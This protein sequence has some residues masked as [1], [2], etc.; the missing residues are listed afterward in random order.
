MT[1]E[2]TVNFKVDGQQVI[3]TLR[4]PEK[5]GKPPV[6]ATVLVSMRN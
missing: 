2:E 4:M 6:K 1:E 3:G 5:V